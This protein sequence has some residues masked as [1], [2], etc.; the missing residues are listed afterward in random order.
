MARPR[1]P[2][3]DKPRASRS[4][5]ALLRVYLLDL[6]LMAMLATIA[7]IVIAAGVELPES[8]LANLALTP[9]LVAAILVIAPIGEEI[10][11]R[12]WLTGRVRDVL[13]SIVFIGGM[14]ATAWLGASDVSGASIWSIAVLI[15]ALGLT[16]ILFRTA[17][18]RPAMRWFAR[19]FPL[20]FWFSTLA[21]ACVHLLNFE[22]GALFVLLPLVLPQFV[23]GALLGYLRVTYG[24]GASIA[25][26]ALHNGTAMALVA[27]ATVAAS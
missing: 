5:V 8:S 22:E 3:Q 2:A 13:A 21:F 23:L 26:H 12:G 16:I 4:A 6:L 14:G 10:A 9:G 18:Q 17:R 1:L 15:V 7:G 20:F 24:L 11:F 19:L 27:L 25:L